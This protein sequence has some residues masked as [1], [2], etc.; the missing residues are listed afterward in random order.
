MSFL[1]T[2]SALMFCAALVPSVGIAADAPARKASADTIDPP[3]NIKRVVHHGRMLHSPAEQ[4]ENT[5]RAVNYELATCHQLD[6][7]HCLLVASMDEQG[8]GDLCVGNDGF[9]IQ[10][11]SDVA[12]AKAIP[13]NRSVYKA[14]PGG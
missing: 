9:V 5:S 14:E 4:P 1:R 6:R 8:G 7:D 2:I 11:L 13:I 10:K 12:A 3:A